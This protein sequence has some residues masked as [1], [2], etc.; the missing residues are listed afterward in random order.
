MFGMQKQVWIGFI[1]GALLLSIAG[2]GGGGGN[3]SGA[4]GFQFESTDGAT[5]KLNALIK[6][7]S[8][9][10][11]KIKPIRDEYNVGFTKNDKINQARIG[12]ALT[13]AAYQAYRVAEL[14]GVALESSGADLNQ[15]RRMSTSL[16]L[17]R[18]RKGK[19]LFELPQKSLNQFLPI[20]MPELV[21]TGG[22]EAFPKSPTPAQVKSLLASL[23]APLKTI[24]DR[25]PDA[26][27][28]T[29]D[30]SSLTIKDP[31]SSVATATV[32][33]GKAEMLGLRTA[34][35]ALRGLVNAAL[36]YE[37]DS[38]TWDYTRDFD[39]A[40]ANLIKGNKVIPRA[41]LMPPSPFMART[42]TGLARMKTFGTLWSAA[43]D[44][45]VKTVT[46]LRAN[47]PGFLWTK[48]G[49]SPM[50][51]N[52]AESTA[53]AFKDYMTR[54]MP[55]PVKIGSKQVVLTVNIPA[56]VANAP[57][58]LKLFVP[59]LK[60]T[61]F[62]A[63]VYWLVPVAGSVADRTYGGLFPVGGGIPTAVIYDRKLTLDRDS[64]NTITSVWGWAFGFWEGS[65]S[66]PW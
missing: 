60:A 48:A 57:A 46:S 65:S 8:I 50:D 15:I 62:S 33:L 34:V 55:L 30:A 59:E 17:L 45:A 56:W 19:E 4:S 18:E 47:R 51:L 36:S 1:L 27:V 26:S 35:Q 52:S 5:A 61:N 2:C 3:V 12:Y 41:T 7:G 49:L 66:Y 42:A 53:L 24:V 58:N 20:M 37:F 22:R 43:A 39:L 31:L 10:A 64:V 16:N 23:E 21:P 29:L 28:N 32:K 13:E 54:R 14:F 25:L 63:Y 44:D 11:A 38:K 9:T 40:F 6:A